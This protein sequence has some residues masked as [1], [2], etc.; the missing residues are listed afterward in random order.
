M[1]LCK[2][3]KLLLSYSILSVVRVFRG[4]QRDC[5]YTYLNLSLFC[6][7]T[8]VLQNSAL[9]ITTCTTRFFL[10]DVCSPLYNRSMF[11]IFVVFEVCLSIMLLKQS[12]ITIIGACSCHKFGHIIR[13]EMHRH[14]SLQ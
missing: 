10:I 5:D 6:D 11:V 3:I 14:K 1:S 9:S 7:L 12:N 8:P 4:R 2:P 13:Q